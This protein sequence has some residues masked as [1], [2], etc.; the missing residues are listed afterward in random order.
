MFNSAKKKFLCEL[1]RLGILTNE[2]VKLLC[3]PS[4]YGD[5]LARRLT[6][7]LEK[8]GLIISSVHKKGVGRGRK[9]YQ[10]NER[11]KDEVLDLIGKES[12]Q[13]FSPHYNLEHQLL[14]NSI[15]INFLYSCNK[16]KNYLCEYITDLEGTNSNN[17]LK[18]FIS[19]TEF[20]PYW[21]KSSFLPDFVVS[22]IQRRTKKRILLFGELDRETLTLKK[23]GG[24]NKNV[25]SKLQMYSSLWESKNFKK[26]DEWFDYEF[27]G[28]RLLW[29]TI[30][31]KRKESIEKLSLIEG[32]GD[33]LWTATYEGIK[34]SSVFGKAW[35]RPGICKNR[36]LLKD[37]S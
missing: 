31:Q 19:E 14:V 17:Q 10:I 7:S 13:S 29:I 23:I 26:Y 34:E 28:F 33:L 16:T 20:V 27:S 22:I 8:E 6:S 30:T 25:Q 18:K 24:K 21:G 1:A 12:I 5:K 32:V 3:Y 2:D 36:S 4:D 37:H 9:F 35:N 11:R 15:I